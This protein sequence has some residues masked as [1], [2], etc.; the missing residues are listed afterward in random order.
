[1][2]PLQHPE[3]RAAVPRFGAS[4]PFPVKLA[5]LAAARWPY[6][7]DSFELSQAQ[8]GAPLAVAA[9]ALCVVYV[10]ALFFTHAQHALLGRHAVGVLLAAFVYANAVIAVATYEAGAAP[11]A[12]L[13]CALHLLHAVQEKLTRREGD[14]YCVTNLVPNQDV[15]AG[16]L[17]PAQ[18]L[19]L[20]AGWFC[21]PRGSIGGAHMLGCCF[22][23]EAGG[24]L[25]QLLCALV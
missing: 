11:L 14:I 8:I 2:G 3:R 17:W 21:A 12:A 20:G 25:V 6:H 16:L 13:L 23:P 9:G 4:P 24:L 19:A 18:A 7:A 5:A 1:M 22:L 10:P 15:V